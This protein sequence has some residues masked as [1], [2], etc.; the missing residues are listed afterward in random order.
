MKTDLGPSQL[1]KTG[2]SVIGD[3]RWGTHFC[4]FYETKQDLLDTLVLF[5]KAG[6]ENNEFC[7]WVVSPPLTVEEAKRALGQAVSDLDGQFAERGLEI[8]D[9]N[10]W[11]LH[12]GQFDPQRALQGWREKL[13]ESFP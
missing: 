1:R 13:T 5:F 11:Y 6:L 9:Y 7:L 8:R 4:C 10:E 12:N 3:V 2:I